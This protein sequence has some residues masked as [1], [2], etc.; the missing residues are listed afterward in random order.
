M[1]YTTDF[2]GKLE[3]TPPLNETEVK[4]I[5]KFNDTRRMERG[6]GP[7]Y[8]GGGGF[9]GQDHEPDIINFNRPDPTQ[10]TL[11][12]QWTVSD[13][14]TKLM[15][16]GG[17]KAYYMAEFLDYIIAHFLGKEPIAKEVNEH[18]HFLQ[19]HTISGII[20]A[21]GE[22]MGDFWQIGVID[23]V[24]YTSDVIG[25]SEPDWK[26]VNWAKENMPKH[27]QKLIA[28]DPIEGEVI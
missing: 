1:G 8:V 2:E 17:E 19:G 13:D 23:N 27:S 22:D 5:K 15:W 4:Y 18:F 6:N 28:V 24:V 11:W 21:R 3:I 25:K 10:P 14:G 12:C 9:A 20:M 16:D 7:Y 26:A